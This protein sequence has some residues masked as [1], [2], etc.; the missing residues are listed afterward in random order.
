MNRQKRLE[1]MQEKHMEIKEREIC[2]FKKE[3]EE[4]DETL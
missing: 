3:E 1:E 2:R 4:K